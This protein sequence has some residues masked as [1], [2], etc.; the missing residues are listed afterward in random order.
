MRATCTNAVNQQVVLL[1]WAWLSIN[2]EILFE[3]ADV[4][5]SQYKINSTSPIQ[6]LLL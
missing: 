5:D 4:Q 6:A 1:H 2:G 3:S